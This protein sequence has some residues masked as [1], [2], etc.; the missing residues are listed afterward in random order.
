M[1]DE[2]EFQ[3]LTEAEFLSLPWDWIGLIAAIV[4]IGVGVWW[5]AYRQPRGKS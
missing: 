2:P 4:L 5:I 3:G 1:K